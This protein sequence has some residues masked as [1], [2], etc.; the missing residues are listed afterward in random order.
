MNGLELSKAYFDAYGL[1]MLRER[2]PRLLPLLAAGLT[3][4]GS[5][6]WGYDDEWSRD[7]DFEPASAC[8]CRERIP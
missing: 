4:S 1:P 8:S 2:F 3:G 6:C 5:E 7:H